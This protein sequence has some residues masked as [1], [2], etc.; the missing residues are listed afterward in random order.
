MH[1]QPVNSQTKS[2]PLIGLLPGVF[3]ATLPQGPYT[4]DE[5]HG[6]AL[7]PSLLLTTS[8]I[9]SAQKLACVTSKLTDKTTPKHR[10]RFWSTTVTCSRPATLPRPSPA[11]TATP[12]TESVPAST[13][14]PPPTP[15]CASGT[16][17]TSACTATAR[18][19][20]TGKAARRTTSASRPPLCRAARRIL[21]LSGRGCGT[22]RGWW[23]TRTAAQ[24]RRRWGASGW[25]ATRQTSRS[26]GGAAGSRPQS[27][28][29]A[30]RHI[31]D[32]AAAPKRLERG[33]QRLM[34]QP[35]PARCSGNGRCQCR[36]R[37]LSAPPRSPTP[38]KT[39]KPPGHGQAGAGPL[40]GRVCGG[41]H[42]AAHPPRRPRPCDSHVCGPPGAAPARRA[43]AFRPRFPRPLVSPGP[44][45]EAAAGARN[46]VKERCLGTWQISPPLAHSWSPSTPLSHGPSPHGT[47][48]HP[49]AWRSQANAALACTPS[50][51][52]PLSPQA[53]STLLLGFCF[54]PFH[55]PR[56]GTPG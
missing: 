54:R 53:P 41:A 22:A 10:P 56:R 30:R 31:V 3:S 51:N 8:P 6:A 9:P 35:P 46:A 44:V 12:S 20:R 16:R 2:P 7:N 43:L 27:P 14:A 38:K 48:T 28:G 42:G 52:R 11:P 24:R 25:P 1:S 21:L 40:P 55:C 26:E 45:M 17:G 33:R 32:R 29:R 37:A 19:S 18:F 23:T 50:T 39:T 49:Q 36:R 5:P 15:A 4:A 13:N 47:Q 34:R